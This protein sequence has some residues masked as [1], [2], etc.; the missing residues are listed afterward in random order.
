MS[1]YTLREAFALVV[2]ASLQGA[3]P[4]YHKAVAVVADALNEN[5]R[6]TEQYVTNT[7]E[8]TLALMQER[9][10]AATKRAE[11][12]EAVARE[13][14]GELDTC[15]SVQIRDECEYAWQEDKDA[16]PCISCW[17][18]VAH[19]A[20]ERESAP[21]VCP[22]CGSTDRA[23]RGIIGCDY[24]CSDPSHTEV[25]Y[26]YIAPPQVITGWKR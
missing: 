22:T 23:V 14:A 8:Q 25:E 16:E 26:P 9:L 21:Y 18:A 2:G 12:A 13:L 3:N 17:L 20:V 19:E 5:E 11:V 1:D 7:A 4:A 15:P 24:E 6:M 10:E